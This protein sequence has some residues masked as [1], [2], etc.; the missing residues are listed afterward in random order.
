MSNLN[1]IDPFL[2]YSGK[3]GI[4]PTNTLNSWKGALSAILSVLEDDERTT[5]FVLSSGDVIKNR[6]QNVNLDISGGTIG[7]YVQR[8]QLAIRHFLEWQSDREAWEKTQAGKKT[9]SE[10]V[11]KTES[12]KPIGVN[13]TSHNMR[14]IS[15]PIGDG[16][17]AFN[18]TL[19]E[20]F[21]MDDLLRLVWGLAIYSADFDPSEMINKFRKPYNTKNSASTELEILN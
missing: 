5:D 11:V 19:P 13:P 1:A 2:E 4:I 6:L 9:K 21:T 12:K 7:L 15:I 8:S 18:L 14:T 10:R 16:S 20:K 3:K 17:G